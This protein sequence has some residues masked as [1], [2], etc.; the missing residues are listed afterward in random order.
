MEY[1]AVDFV[2]KR[3]EI[4]NRCKKAL[5]AKAIQAGVPAKEF[6]FGN[7]DLPPAVLTPQ[8]I[9]ELSKRLSHIN[10]IPYNPNPVVDFQQSDWQNIW[11]FKK[12]LET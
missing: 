9:E 10:L 1:E 4:E 6:F 2:D 3:V 5:Q 12:I 11:R 7:I 8:K